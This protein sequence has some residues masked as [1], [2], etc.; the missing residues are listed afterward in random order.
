MAGGF[1]I[2]SG[3]VVLVAIATVL[4]TVVARAG[5]HLSLD[6]N[7][8]VRIEDAYPTPY[9][10]LEVQAF[11]RY[12]HNSDDPRGDDLFTLSPRLE[13]G[14]FRN[15]QISLAVPYRVGD[16]SDTDQ[17]NVQI[18][19]LYNFNQEGEWLPAFSAGVGVDQPFGDMSGGTETEL[20]AILTKSIGS[21]G[22]SY[23]P[24]RVH[25]NASWF[26]NYDTLPDERSDRY[27]IG[28]GYSQPLTN[29]ALIV[30]D[31]Y[32]EQLRTE[33]E[34]ENMAELGIRYQLDPQTV[35]SA[36][37]GGGFADE[38]PDYRVL[39][40]IQHTLSWPTLFGFE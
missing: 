28:I 1:T 26:H 31:V 9:N 13:A 37:A 29:D 23:L 36:S 21:F 5:D 27:L 20:K 38:S 30:V 22:T 25:L 4:Q 33:T 39:V 10:G 18:E 17:G 32:R 16:A 3:R 12:D 35:F 7:L 15:G 8:P 19:A 34:Y 24:R 11:S 14:A 2:Q 6:E 40:G